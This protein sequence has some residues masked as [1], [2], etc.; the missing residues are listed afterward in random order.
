MEGG[1]PSLNPW[2]N[3]YLLTSNGALGIL[4][5][6]GEKGLHICIGLEAAMEQSGRFLALRLRLVLMCALTPAVAREVAP[7]LSSAYNDRE[8]LQRHGTQKLLAGSLNGSC[9]DL[10]CLWIYT[11]I[12]HEASQLCVVRTHDIDQWQHI[13]AI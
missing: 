6:T 12:T 1:N 5:K 3:F 4:Q 10:T 7:F 11:I 8:G 9:A 2:V 13:R